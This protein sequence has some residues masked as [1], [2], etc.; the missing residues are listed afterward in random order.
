[1][2]HDGKELPIRHLKIPVGHFLAPHRNAPQEVYYI[3]KARAQLLGI[4]D[5]EKN[6]NAVDP[7][8]ILQNAL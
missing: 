3:L 7:V 6:L 2:R 1:M 8:Y 5:K 4:A